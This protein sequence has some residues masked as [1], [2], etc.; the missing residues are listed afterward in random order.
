[1]ERGGVGTIG[2]EHFT[3]LYSR[4]RSVA[5][6]TGNIRAGW[7]KAGLFPFNPDKVLCDIPKPPTEAT[8]AKPSA[9]EQVVRLPVSPATPKSAGGVAS[10]YHL[11][12]S[13]VEMVDETSKLRL[14]RHVQKLTNATQVSFAE[15]ALLSEQVQF[16]NNINCEA[17]VRRSAKAEI[18]GTARVMSYEDLELARKE[19]ALK[20]AAKEAKKAAKE[21]KKAAKE[22]NVAKKPKTSSSNNLRT[23]A[24]E[25]LEQRYAPVARMW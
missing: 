1:M 24:G 16:L 3:L 20:T 23:A 21:P 10:L 22:A 4:A 12:K 18:L 6:T 11:I 7:A 19:R 2:K 25:M 5:F 17:K 8:A 15:R 13:D 14:E 9:Q